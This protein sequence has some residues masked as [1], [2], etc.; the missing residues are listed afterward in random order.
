MKRR[1][2]YAAAATIGVFAF[3]AAVGSAR[4]QRA[5]SPLGRSV[6][7]GPLADC[8]NGNGN[9]NGCSGNGSATT[10][11]AL[12]VSPGLISFNATAP[13]ALIA[14]SSTASV[15]FT[16]N[17]N[18][19]NVWTL[20]AGTTS[21]TFPGCLTVPTSAVSVRCASASV[22]GGKGATSSCSA[23]NFTQMPSVLP[24]I[25]VAT[26]GEPQSQSAS[27]SISL[28]YQ[29]ADSWQ[30]VPNVCPLNITYTVNAP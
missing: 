6:R 1:A 29:L 18:K 23:A 10:I 24:G 25:V 28:L 2:I 20:S 14:G 19:S 26:G 21:T 7:F 30:Y 15:S 4:A 9:G 12:T 13:G 27:Y 16:I 8:G 22:S 5:S 17:A 11:S 3:V